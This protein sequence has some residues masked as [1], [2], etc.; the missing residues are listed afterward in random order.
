[1]LTAWGA[2][3]Y[4]GPMLLVNTLKTSGS[5]TSGLRIIAG[6]MVVSTVVPVLIR[7]PRTNL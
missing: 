5:Y 6:V 7:P 2:A 3:S 1:M 4:F